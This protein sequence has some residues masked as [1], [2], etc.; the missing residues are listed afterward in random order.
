MPPEKNLQ[1]RILNCTV[2]QYNKTLID[3]IFFHP[4]VTC[5]CHDSSLGIE[6]KSLPN[7]SK[8]E[9]II[10]LLT[11]YEGNSTFIVPSFKKH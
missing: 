7:K 1:F 10:H 4:K 9:Y 5:S 11:G 3:L 2:V 6:Q 8:W